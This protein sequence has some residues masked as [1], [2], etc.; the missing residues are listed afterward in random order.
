[1]S[2]TGLLAQLMDRL[3]P[4]SIADERQA[5]FTLVEMLVASAVM[6]V[7]V[8]GVATVMLAMQQVGNRAI[9]GENA[10]TT[11]RAGLLQFQ[12]DLQAAN[13]LVAWTSTVTSYASELQLDLGPTGGTQQ[14]ITWSCS[15]GTLW[16]DIGTAAGTGVPEVTG[17]TNCASTTNPPFSFYDPQGTSLL[18]I[19]NSVNS[20]IVTACSVRIQG[21]VNVSAGSNTTP[22][23]E[24]V[25]TRLANWVQGIQPCP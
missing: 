7:I 18:S 8:G 19:P 16:R 3:R 9:S 6:T 1:M 10:S 17:V 23:T 20:A 11:A 15:S 12:R 5:G 22:F 13:P 4:R 24:S 14:T 25:S 2:V 21:Y